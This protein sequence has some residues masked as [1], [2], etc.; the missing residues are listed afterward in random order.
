MQENALGTPLDI[1]SVR[2]GDL[3]FWKGH[4]AIARDEA[5]FVHANAFHM[6]VAIE[7]IA[8]A[9]ARIS[10]AGGAITSVKRL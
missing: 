5:T 2:R 10:A 1:K 8:A 3:V 9:I 6:M 4:V 7:P